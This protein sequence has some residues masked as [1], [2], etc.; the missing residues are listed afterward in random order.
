MSE[1]TRSEQTTQKLRLHVNGEYRSVEVETNETL[2]SV[3]R[4]KLK[5]FGTRQGCGI[6]YCGACAVL[7]DRKPVSSCIM[8]AVQVEDKQLTTVEGLS[9]NGNLHPIQQAFLDHSAF[10]CSYCTPGFILTAKAL[11]D[12]NPAPS[13]EQIREYLV[14][15]LCRCGSYYNIIEAVEDAAVR[16]QASKHIASD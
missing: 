3:L 1:G 13:R 4:D 9:Q 15:N 16:M 11:L 2:L 8:L 14:G 5:L 6:G 10:Q 7:V 12:E